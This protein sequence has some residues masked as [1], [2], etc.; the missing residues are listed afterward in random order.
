MYKELLTKKELAARIKCSIRTIDRMV[1]EGLP[2]S[3][4]GSHP[5]FDLIVL[6]CY[7]KG[8]SEPLSCMVNV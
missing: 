5:R 3:R 8:L 4:L 6:G 2:T 7:V 1:K